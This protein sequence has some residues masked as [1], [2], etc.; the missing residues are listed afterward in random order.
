MNELCLKLLFGNAEIL[1]SFD[2]VL[3]DD[4]TKVHA[5][6]MDQE[7]KAKHRAEVSGRLQRAFEMAHD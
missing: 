2:T 4:Y 3:F 7:K 5:P 6:M 1:S